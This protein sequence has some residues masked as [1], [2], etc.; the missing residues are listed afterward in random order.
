MQS[1]KLK[2]V[3]SSSLYEIKIAGLPNGTYDYEFIIDDLFFEVFKSNSLTKGLVNVGMEMNKNSGLFHTSYQFS[4][5]IELICDNCLNKGNF[6][7]QYQH[8]MIYKM[9]LDTENLK[10]NIYSDI[11]FIHPNA[12]KINIHQ[13]LF[14]YIHLAIPMRTTCELF[15]KDCSIDLNNFNEV[16]D[17][18]TPPYW[19]KLK[20]LK[21]ENGTS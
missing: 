12:E 17:K 2:E 3:H 11:V 8:K 4:G 5:F 1:L 19:E 16:N 14:D 20:K 15:S 18:E 6:P 10:K 13:E 7:I 9:S 21:S